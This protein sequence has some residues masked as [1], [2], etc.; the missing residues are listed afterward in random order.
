MISCGDLNKDE[1]YFHPA[2]FDFLLFLSERVL[3][4]APDEILPIDY[5]DVEI[6]CNRERGRGIQS[7]YLLKIN[8]AYWDQTKQKFLKAVVD[9]LS[10][11]DWNG[12][13]F[14]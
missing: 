3:K 12:S 13:Y 2:I 5:D 1:E 9:I 6:I 11:N 10:Q 4:Q 14:K 8:P 7:E